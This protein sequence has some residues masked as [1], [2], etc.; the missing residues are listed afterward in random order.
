MVESVLLPME[1][2]NKIFLYIKSDTAPLIKHYWNMK[3]LM[4]FYDIRGYDSNY[5]EELIAWEVYCCSHRAMKII[6]I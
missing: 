2:I 4:N 5:I 1:L 3:R 6:N